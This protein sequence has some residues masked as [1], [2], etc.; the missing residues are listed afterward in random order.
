MNS[1]LLPRNFPALLGPPRRSLPPIKDF[2]PH[3]SETIVPNIGWGPPRWPT[4]LAGVCHYHVAPAAPSGRHGDYLHFNRVLL[5]EPQ[6]DW[7]QNQETGDTWF[8]LVPLWLVPLDGIYAGRMYD[9]PEG[10]HVTI[11]SLHALPRDPDLL[12][13]MVD[14]FG[15]ILKHAQLRSP[16]H[17]MTCCRLAF[18]PMLRPRRG[19]P[20]LVDLDPGTDLATVMRRLKQVVGLGC[21]GSRCHLRFGWF[22]SGNE[23]PVDDWQRCSLNEMD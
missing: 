15:H 16:P 12:S 13:R 20:D 4:D 2:A 10:T 7:H 14:R 23:A 18:S 6:I 3:A 21:W 22:A 1:L 17:I 11:A 19:R 9:P 5:M 8:G